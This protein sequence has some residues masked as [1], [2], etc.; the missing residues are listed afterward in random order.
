MRQLIGR[1]LGQAK[2]AFYYVWYL[3]VQLMVVPFV[4]TQIRKL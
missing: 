3:F 1:L 4:V 2:A